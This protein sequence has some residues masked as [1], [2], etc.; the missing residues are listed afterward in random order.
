MDRMVN[1][2]GAHWVELDVSLALQQVGVGLHQRRFVPAVR[3]GSG[4]SVRLV[5]VL[6]VAPAERNQQLRHGVRGGRREQEMYVVGHL[7]VGVQFTSGGLEGFSQ[8]FAV[9]ERVLVGEE[10]G[11]AVVASL[12]HVQGHTGNVDSRAA[13]HG[14]ILTG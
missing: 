5:D 13:Q 8:P 1:H 9:G 11:F 7:H 4:A 2:A 12:H 6:D 10:A 3:Q 14:I